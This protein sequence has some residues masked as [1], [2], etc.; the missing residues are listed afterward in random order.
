AIGVTPA[1]RRQGV[2]R[3]MLRRHLAAH[4]EA[5]AW[6]AEVTVAER[7]WIEPAPHDERLAVAASLL[8]GAGL[9]PV[10]PEAAILGVDR[11]A[12]SYRRT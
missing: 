1:H 6:E 7:D 10:H 8:T 9:R 12:V 11:R 5:T 4:D 2:A 3:E